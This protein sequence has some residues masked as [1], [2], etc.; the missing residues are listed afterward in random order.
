MELIK[1]T[2][3]AFLKQ[4]WSFAKLHWKLLLI[5][6]AIL[7][8]AIFAKNKQQVISTLLQ[9]ATTAHQEH[10]AD[11]AQLQT[12]LQHEIEQRTIIQKHYD[13]MIAQIQASHNEEA[14]AISERY[15]AQIKALI[16][17]YKEHP[18]TMAQQISTQFSIPIVQFTEIKQS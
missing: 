13:D 12:Q 3:K 8:A 5:G 17:Q 4:S 10:S 9:S 1:Q 16:E 11:I 14:L 18:E 6:F 7:F 2:T 15:E